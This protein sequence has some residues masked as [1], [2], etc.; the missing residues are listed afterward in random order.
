MMTLCR[1]I[2]A[3][4]LLALAHA[5]TRPEDTKWLAAKAVEAGVVATGT[6]LLYKGQC[7]FIAVPR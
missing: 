4:A 2:L 6:G 1:F 7:M 5:G 3:A